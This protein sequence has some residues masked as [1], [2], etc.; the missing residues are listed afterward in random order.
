MRVLSTGGLTFNGDTAAANA[1]DDYEEG[2]WTPG[3][4]SNFGAFSNAVGNYVKIGKVVHLTFQFNYASGSSS[5]A[6]QVTGL[7]FTVE[8]HNPGSGI[9]STNLVYSTVSSN[10]KVYLIWAEESHTQS[11]IALANPL[12][13]SVDAS[14]GFIRGSL[15][16]VST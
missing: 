16:Y 11:Y 6:G 5:N 13:G 9:Q 8:A 10:T 15:T 2:T 12:H 1:L 14:A 7:P 4:G 3:S